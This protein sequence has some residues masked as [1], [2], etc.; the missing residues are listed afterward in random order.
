MSETDR[1]I[2]ILGAGP[3]GV[4][5]A[6][7]AAKRGF[8]V[9][10]YERGAVGEHVLRWGHVTFFSPWP[11]NRSPWGED[12]LRELEHALGDDEVFPTG[13]A[14]VREYLAPLASHPLL[15]GRVHTS[16]EVLGVSRTHALKGDFI[17]NPERAGAPFLI[18]VR[19]ADGERYEEADVVLD[20]TGAY[21]HPGA[22][23]PGGLPAIGEA[24]SE[25]FIER[26][27]PDL[28]GEDAEDYA[29]KRVLVVGAGYSAVTTLR[30]LRDLKD[31]APGTQISWL[32]RSED[33]PYDVLP[34]DPLPQR[35]AL[36]TFGNDAAEGRIEG[37]TPL[38]GAYVRELRPT[39]AGQLEVT[40]QSG[41]G[42]RTFTVDRVV[43]NVGYKPDTELARELQVHL[44]YAS[45]GPMK[46]AASL[47]AAGGGGGDC[48]TQQ[49]AGVET[50]L[51]PEPDFYVL[52]AKSYGRNSAFL[53]KLGVEQIGEVMARLA[54]E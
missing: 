2:A 26:Y 33:A 37:I 32:M 27:I 24:R 40:I 44:C 4:E 30:A 9:Q 39:A 14:Y 46:L 43:S 53:I 35:V 29:G 1:R 23:G 19:D 3:I 51:T 28:E 20:T 17:A 5:A 50:L 7:L 21:R 34:D 48:L 54:G 15:E 8:D 11:L 42:E 25:A 10:V 41:A 45:E 36:A 31:H 6:L 16:C 49:S 13:E 12:A 38:L 22:L 47:L 52:G 18:L